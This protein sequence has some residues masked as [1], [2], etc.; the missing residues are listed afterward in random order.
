MT[1]PGDSSDV[2]W[3]TLDLSDFQMI[4]CLS[5]CSQPRVIYENVPGSKVSLS[6]LVKNKFVAT[7]TCGGYYTLAASG[8]RLKS[9]IDK[10]KAENH[11][12]PYRLA[13]DRTD[14]G[15]FLL[16]IPPLNN[17]ILSLAVY[18][19]S[20]FIIV[21]Q[22]GIPSQERYEVLMTLVREGCVKYCGDRWNLTNR[23]AFQLF[24]CGSK[25]R[26]EVSRTEEPH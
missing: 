5:I 12:F 13:Y 25:E 18:G 23:G 24:A 7:M 15:F 4:N 2:V 9:E 3:K 17:E 10:F 6:W 14:G 16:R 20:E 19:R 8:R 26:H 11:C 21:F 1:L 22:R